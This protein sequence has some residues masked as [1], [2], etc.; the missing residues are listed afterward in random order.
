MNFDPDAK[1]MKHKH[2]GAEA[3]YVKVSKNQGRETTDFNNKIHHNYLH[4]MDAEQETIGIKAS[5]NEV[6]SI[7]AISCS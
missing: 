1:I 6:S 2:D 7:F 4:K 3:I 5:G